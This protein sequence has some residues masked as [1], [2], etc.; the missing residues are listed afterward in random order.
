MEIDKLLREQVLLRIKYDNPWWTTGAIPE[1]FKDLPR[2]LYLD[3]FYPMIK[4][5]DVKRG[6]ILMGSRR[7]GKTVML[8]H[9]IDRLIKEGV[10]PQKIIYLSIDTPIYNNISLEDLFTMT[11]E[12]MSQPELD[13]EYYVFYDEIQYLKDWEIHLKSLIDSYRDV[14]FVA[15]GSASAALKMKSQESGAGRFTDFKLPPLTFHEYIHLL[16][17]DHLI[18]PKTIDWQGQSIEVFDTIDIQILNQHF[19][20][21]INYGGYP[22]I[23]FSESMRRNPGQFIRHDIVD[24]VLLR[25]L[26][27]LYGIRD[28]QELYRLFV[29]IVFRSGGEFSFED[30]SKESGIKKETV[31]KYVEYLEAAFLIKVINRVDANARRLQRITTFKIYLTNPALRCALFSPITFNDN[32]MGNMVETAIFSQWVQRDNTEVYY[33]NWKDGRKQGEVDMVGLDWA[34]QKPSWCIE[35][36]WSDRYI[37]ETGKLK[38]LLRFLDNNEL[39]S[40]IVTSISS[41]GTKELERATLHF[42][43]SA[44][45]AYIIGYNTIKQRK[46]EMGIGM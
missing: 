16:N 29:H 26:P 28:T 39:K 27:S 44:L 8:F 21:Y 36:K 40:T 3:I 22:E 19:L 45:Y 33:A 12:A 18:V 17:L 1:D 37:N 42:I 30:L 35:I 5:Q 46:V 20:N 32:M 38:S 9:A 31:K 41:F 34:H 24:K 11:R 25:D 14:K 7:V 2:R 4:L 23:V 13:G 43:P 6:I 10:N 15:S